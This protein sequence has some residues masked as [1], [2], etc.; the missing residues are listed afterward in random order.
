[1][2]TYQCECLTNYT[3]CNLTTT[4]MAILLKETDHSSTLEFTYIDN[5]LTWNKHIYL[6]KF[7]IKLWNNLHCQS[8]SANSYNLTTTLMAFLLKETDHSSTLEFK[9]IDN[10]LTWNKHIYLQKIAIKLWNNLP[11]Q[12]ISTNS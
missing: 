1:M 10:K 2:H 3:P 5:K 4:L 12:S 11:C 8:I 7:A 9:Y 6:Q